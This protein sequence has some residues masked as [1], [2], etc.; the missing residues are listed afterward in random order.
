MWNPKKWH[1]KERV[2]D[3]SGKKETE[4]YITEQLTEEEREASVIAD[5][6]LREMELW[7]GLNDSYSYTVSSVDQHL[8]PSNPQIKIPPNPF[9]SKHL[10]EFY[11]RHPIYPWMGDGF[12]MSLNAAGTV[13]AAGRSE[14]E[15]FGD[16]AVT[17]EE[18]ESAEDFVGSGT[19]EVSSTAAAEFNAGR[20]S[21]TSC[22]NSV[23]ARAVTHDRRKPETCSNSEPTTNSK[24]IPILPHRP[25]SNISLHS[26]ISMHSLNT[27]FKLS[28]TD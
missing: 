9:Y 21:G 19:A 6:M 12:V 10:E 22:G 8:N 17:L 24:P 1:L 11:D 18:E 20:K 7:P 28:I 4:K 13:L 25:S 16:A 27:A 5:L 15:Y 14:S 26:N 3:G 2:F 23:Q